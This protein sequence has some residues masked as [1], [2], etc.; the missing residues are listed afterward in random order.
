MKQLTKYIQEAL[1][2]KNAKIGTPLC[3]KYVLFVPYGITYT[4]MIKKFENN[5]YSDSYRLSFQA[6][7]N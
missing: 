2:S 7:G 3:D 1:I 6:G 4:D 5:K